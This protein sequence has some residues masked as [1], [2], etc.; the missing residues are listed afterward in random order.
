VNTR[1]K[2]ANSDQE[3]EADPRMRAI[4]D[5]ALQME[6][7]WA[8]DAKT[9]VFSGQGSDEDIDNLI[10]LCSDVGDKPCVT[11]ARAMRQARQP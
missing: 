9:K 10:H 2:V 11:R 6:R 1:S 5:D 4:S 7:E 3:L 8:E